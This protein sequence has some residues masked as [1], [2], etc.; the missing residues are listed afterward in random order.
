MSLYV[1]VNKHNRSFL[2]M[3][4][5]LGAMEAILNLKVILYKVNFVNG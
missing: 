2:T 5:I 1:T 4:L 3:K